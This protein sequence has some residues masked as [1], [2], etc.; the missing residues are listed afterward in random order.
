VGGESMIAFFGYLI[1]MLWLLV[2][3]WK[4]QEPTTHARSEL[5]RI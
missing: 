1:F 5:E 4:I 2:R 3:G